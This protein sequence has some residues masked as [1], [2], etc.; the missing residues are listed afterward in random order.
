MAKAKRVPLNR[1]VKPET[2]ESV[3]MLAEVME[4]SEGEVVDKAVGFFEEHSAS[5]YVAADRPAPVVNG[6]MAAPP[7]ASRPETSYERTNRERRERARD[8]DS[9]DDDSFDRSD[10]FVSG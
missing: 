9:I 3:K 6:S 2:F 7:I 5:G 4:C 10:E 1:L 8:L